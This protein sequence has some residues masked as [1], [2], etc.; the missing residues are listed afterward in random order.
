MPAV[1]S[2]LTPRPVRNRLLRLLPP[3]DLERLWPRLELVELSLKA[4]LLTPGAAVDSVHFVETGTVSMI[5]TLGDG[6]QIEVGLVGPEG[7]TGLPLLLGAS[8]SPLEGM[9]QVNG[10]ALRLPAAAFRAALAEMPAFLALLLR[11]VDAFHFQ[12]AQSAACNSRHQIEQR[13]ARWLLMT[14][15][16]VEGDSFSMTQEFMST[17]LGVQR[18]GVTLAIGALQR[19]GLVQHHRGNMR[20]LD[21]PGLE[22]AACECYET[23]RK[24][25]DWLWPN[26]PA[27]AAVR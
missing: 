16:R 3:A 1:S 14:H 5:A 23:V 19:A 18:P 22:A 24:R 4:V 7:M 2:G 6:T 8:T 20:V 11:Y 10:A 9:V 13:L 27:P 12:V 26:P 15:D 21:R 25:F 17:M